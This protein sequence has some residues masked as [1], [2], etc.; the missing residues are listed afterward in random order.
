M[1]SGVLLFLAPPAFSQGAANYPPASGHMT[2][3]P[4]SF[5]APGAVG[6]QYVE[7]FPSFVQPYQAT[8]GVTQPAA[9][10]FRSATPRTRGRVV[11]GTRVYSRGYNSAPA[12]YANPLPQG[13]LYWPGSMVAPDYTPFSRY[14]TQGQGYQVSP[15][16]SNFYGGYWMGHALNY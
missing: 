1:A 10:G 2:Y 7:T 4:P 5:P 9:P 13:Q 14:R 11:R 15:Y 6:S 3:I 8:P 12:P 16:G